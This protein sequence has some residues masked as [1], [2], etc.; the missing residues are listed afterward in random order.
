MAMTRRVGR[1]AYRGRRAG[2][3]GRRAYRARRRIY[4]KAMYQ[5]QLFTETF[6]V[7]TQAQPP[8]VPGVLADGTIRIQ[9]GTQFTAGKFM[10]KMTDVPQIQNYANLYQFYKILKVQ[11]I[12]IP[13]FS[14]ADPNSA[15][16]NQTLPVAA[17]ENVRMVYAINDATN[18]L[19]TPTS[20]LDV[21]EDNGCKIKALTRP[22]KINFA[23][24]VA[25]DSSDPTTNNLIPVQPKFRPWL[26][27]GADDGNFQ[28]SEAPLHV[29][30]DWVVSCDNTS[31]TEFLDV[32]DVYFK[33]TFVCKDP[34]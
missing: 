24:K 3:L 9:A 11:A 25:V 5:S 29:G 13:K 6:K 8:T 7:N 1:R 15:Q 31:T 27:F 12:V 20:E 19:A 16:Y 22:L 28:N 23:P 33:V 2:P 18:D 14:N 32:A 17:W 4:R 26:G 30:V 10:V 21:L 34:R